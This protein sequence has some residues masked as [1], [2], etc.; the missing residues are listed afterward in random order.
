[1]A[2]WSRRNKIPL[3]VPGPSPWYLRAPWASLVTSGGRWTWNFY[4]EPKLAGLSR[5]I[6]PN[7]TTVLLLDFGCYVFPLTNDR[8]LIWHESGR[9]EATKTGP[10]KITFLILQLNELHP[11]ADHSSAAA[12]MRDTKRWI[13]FEG[14]SS[15]V[16]EVPTEVCEGEHAISPPAS[17]VELLEILVLADYGS[18]VG[19]H[20]DKMFRAIFAFDFKER[21]LTVL[22]QQWFNEGDY[23]FGYQWI[24]RVQ[25]ESTTG[26]IVGEGIRLG[27]FRLAPSATQIA[28][29][30]HKDVFYH[31]EHEF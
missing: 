13:R 18:D 14:T 31:P 25:R 12:D 15:V 6:A 26:Q 9:E 21:R 29:W 5:L 4:D 2:L 8:I 27:N 20:F 28:E 16:F 7:K 17:F 24:T 11:F 10:P 1:M 30:L 23:D 19:N 22:P 3:T